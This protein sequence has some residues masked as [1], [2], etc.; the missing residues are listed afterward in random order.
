MNFVDTKSKNLKIEIFQIY[1]DIFYLNFL[2]LVAT[3]SKIRN[4]INNNLEK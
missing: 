1:R 4:K 2:I 3:I